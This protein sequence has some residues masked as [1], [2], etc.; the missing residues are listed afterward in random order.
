MI[1]AVRIVHECQINFT[2]AQ[3]AIELK[4]QI[5]TSVKPLHDHDLAIATDNELALS[6][7]RLN[8]ELQL[9]AGLE[10]DLNC[11]RRTRRDSRMGEKGRRQRRQQDNGGTYLQQNLNSHQC[12]P[13]ST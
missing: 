12:G 8:F 4:C 3:E 11:R 5:A 7:W 6:A 2:I 1:G 13:A 9:A 10:R